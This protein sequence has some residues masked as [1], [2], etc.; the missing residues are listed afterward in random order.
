MRMEGFKRLEDLTL[1]DD[2]MFG[3]VMSDFRLLKPLLEFI[4]DMRIRS[5]RSIEP[6]KS[7]KSGFAARGVRLDLYVE[8]EHGVVYNVEVQT[9]RAKSLPLRMR[10]YQSAIDVHVLS[11]GVD[12]ADL[13]RSYIIFICNHDPYKQGRYIYRFENRCLEDLSLPFGDETV[14]V[15]VNTRGT[16][17]EV[18][19]ELKEIIRYLR[20]GTVSGDYSRE[21]EQAVHGI[22]T[23]EERR[24]EYMIMMVKEQELINKG[25]EQ[26]RES[27]KKR[28]TALNNLL[29]SDG[30]IYDLMRSFKDPEYQNK[31]LEEYG[32]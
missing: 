19:D 27:E 14:K 13:R 8:D 6:Q 29:T 20:D 12:Y 11:P 32:L 3:A 25:I 2:Y 18:S 22:K 15:I 31:L 17:G 1:M 7:M 21:L 10:Y 23:S 28:I 16:V 24:H 4:L 30:R 9:T 26:G 5:I